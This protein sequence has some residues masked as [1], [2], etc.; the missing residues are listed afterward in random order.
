MR[1]IAG[2]RRYAET[3]QGRQSYDTEESSRKAASHAEGFRRMAE[4]ERVKSQQGPCTS[5]RFAAPSSLQDPWTCV[6]SWPC[7]V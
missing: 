4:S 6:P 3:S 1:A 2:W 5:Q 7:S